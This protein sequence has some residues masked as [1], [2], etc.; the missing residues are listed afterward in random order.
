[1]I[2]LPRLFGMRC[3]KDGLNLTDDRNHA[4]I[5]ARDTRRGVYRRR[6]ICRL[7]ANDAGDREEARER[8]KETTGRTRTASTE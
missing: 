2:V 7:V 6:K 5:I 1:M 4:R 8:R 3:R